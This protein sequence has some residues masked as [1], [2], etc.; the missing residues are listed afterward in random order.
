[1]AYQRRN[2]FERCL[3]KEGNS[4]RSNF[5][6]IYHNIHR[7]LNALAVNSQQQRTWELSSLDTSWS[8]DDDDKSL[9]TEDLE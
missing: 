1:V 9:D 7:C 8:D 5:S 4:L 2:G 3:E 6:G